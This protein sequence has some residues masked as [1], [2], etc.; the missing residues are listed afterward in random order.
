MSENNFFELKGQRVR[1]I[2]ST[3]FEVTIVTELGEYKLMHY[4]DCCESV[5]VHEKSMGE[6]P[7]DNLEF[8]PPRKII[9]AEDDHPDLDPP[10]DL[11]SYTWSRFVLVLEGD[12][13]ILILFLGESNGYYG[14][15]VDFVKLD[16]RSNPL[17]F[18]SRIVIGR[19][20]GT[21]P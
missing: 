2:E 18:Q 20:I 6:N 13:K 19:S 9:L 12:L 5:C 16:E 11:E 15:T 21:E 7:F 10:T 14:E 17:Y 8:S 4:Q 1:F 3:E